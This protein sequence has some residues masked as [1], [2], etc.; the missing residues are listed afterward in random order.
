MTWQEYETIVKIIY[1]TIGKANGVKIECY[2]SSCKRIGRSGS[3]HQIDVLTSHSDGLHSY[4]TAIECKYWQE[5]VNKDVVMKSASINDDC[6]FSKSIIV[7]KEGFT[8]DAIVYARSVNVHLVELKEHNATIEKNELIKFYLHLEVTEPNLS[9]FNINLQKEEQGLFLD[10]Y[11]TVNIFEFLIEEP[12]NKIKSSKEVIAVFINETVIASQGVEFVTETVVFPKGTK[13][14]HP[15]F[16]QKFS[17]DSV[18]LTGYN[19]RFTRIDSD[20]FYNEVLMKMKLL[21][22]QRSFLVT[23]DGKLRDEKKLEEL[24]MVVGH[25]I[26]YKINGQAKKFLL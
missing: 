15:D 25:N 20:Y 12:V 11:N 1:E 14:S 5:T 23:I 2:G 13:I 16:K 22:E 10:N 9:G 19:R 4:F 26:H 24:K 18:H 17:I 21:F 8:P 3:E 7:S 6:G